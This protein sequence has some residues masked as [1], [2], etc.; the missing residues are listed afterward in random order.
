METS[1]ERSQPGS[2]TRD[3]LAIRNDVRIHLVPRAEIRWIE[4]DGDHVR[5][6]TSERELR[7]RATL[8]SF[9]Q[10]LG[11]G[12]CASTGVPS[13]ISAPFAKSNGTIVAITSRSFVTG[14]NSAF[15][16]R[17]AT[18]LGALLAPIA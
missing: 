3:H 2:G 13:C 8:T 14:G 16:A 18:F 1:R 7:T 6:P 15:R 12:C 5:I 4:A 11:A 10:E 9:E 17:A